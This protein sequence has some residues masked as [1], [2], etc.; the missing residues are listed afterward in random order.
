MNADHTCPSCEAYKAGG[1]VAADELERLQRLLIAWS[2]E[3]ES[4]VAL[5]MQREPDWA[6]PALLSATDRLMQSAA[7]IRYWRGDDPSGK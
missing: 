1:K 4:I 2:V 3:C 5:T 6:P 7:A